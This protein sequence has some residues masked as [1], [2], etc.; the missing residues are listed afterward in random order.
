MGLAGNPTKTGLASA[1]SARSAVSLFSMT[2]TAN[3]RITLERD[4]ETAPFAI[5]CGLAGW[6][7][8]AIR[9]RP[10]RRGAAGA[11]RARPGLAAA[12]DGIDLEQI[13]GSG[14]SGLLLYVRG[15]LRAARGDRAGTASDLRE[16]GEIYEAMGYSNP[17]ILPWRSALASVLPG[18]CRSAVR[19]APSWPAPA[20]RGSARYRIALRASAL[21]GDRDE[22]IPLLRKQPRC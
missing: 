18:P 6:F 7:V 1:L 21:L 9:P 8:R 11:G 15:R 22:R 5:T 14:P 12:V 10:A 17:N 16:C 13:R 3:A 20:R 19:A 4:G 2:R